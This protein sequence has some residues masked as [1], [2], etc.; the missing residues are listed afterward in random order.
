ML[1]TQFR[2]M[3]QALESPD[4]AAMQRVKD[5]L[6]DLNA[7]L[8]TDARG[9]HTQEQFDEFMEKYGDL[10]PDD[11]RDLEE[12][13]DSLARRAA[14]AERMMQS[15][16]PQQRDELA[17]LMAGRWRTWTWH[18]EMAQLGEALRSRRPDLDWCGR[19][20]MRG[21]QPLGVGDAT[22]AVQDL[23]DLDELES[24]RRPG[25]PGRLAGRHRRGGGAPRARPAGRR[26]PGRAAP[27]GARARGAGLPQPHRRPA[28]S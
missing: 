10:F 4:P 5:M 16:S 14:A 1:D 21:E 13:V 15:L 19:E 17:A 27:A 12:L 22:S 11:P 2:G 9:E 18:G 23:A 3:K 25:L 6:A 8:A 26:R 7:M 24:A 28:A 20:R